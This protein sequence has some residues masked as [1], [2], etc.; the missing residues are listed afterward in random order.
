[1]TLA[2]KVDKYLD[3]SQIDSQNSS[4]SGAISGQSLILTFV[5]DDGSLPSK[6]SIP[7]SLAGTPETESYRALINTS[8]T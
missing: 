3:I 6:R 5:K 4:G 8:G 1:M 2:I 7:V